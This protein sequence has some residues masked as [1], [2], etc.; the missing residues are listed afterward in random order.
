M[1]G[2]RDH[3][4]PILS[5]ERGAA[6]IQKKEVILLLAVEHRSPYKSPTLC[7]ELR[8]KVKTKA[9]VAID[10]TTERICR[11]Y[12]NSLPGRRGFARTNGRYRI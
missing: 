5:V 10:R 7:P 3:R 11:L 9:S 2:L 4:S 1:A 12:R 8:N 6:G